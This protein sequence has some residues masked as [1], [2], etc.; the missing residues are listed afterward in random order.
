M[1]HL[2]YLNTLVYLTETTQSTS[3]D[4]FSVLRGKRLWANLTTAKTWFDIYFSIPPTHYRGFSFNMTTQIIHC[5]STLYD[6]MTLDEPGWD[7][8]LARAE[9]DFVAILDKATYHFQQA[10][11]VMIGGAT[12]NYFSVFVKFFQKAR[13]G[14]IAKLQDEEE[15]MGGG[16]NTSIPTDIGTIPNMFDL[17]FLDNEAF[18]NYVIGQ[19]TGGTI[20][21]AAS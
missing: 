21:S 16:L 11:S 4:H 5:M 3:G 18:W 6:L 15:N 10:A 19:D 14:L 8:H 13:P 20:A 7:K 12:E 9:V 1:L 17:E 2:H